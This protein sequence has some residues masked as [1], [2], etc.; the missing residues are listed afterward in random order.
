[1]RSVNEES[2][3]NCVCTAGEKVM[4][5]QP[6]QFDHHVRRVSPHRL[7]FLVFISTQ[8]LQT[9]NVH[10]KRCSQALRILNIQGKPLGRGRIRHFSPTLTLRIGCLHAEE[11]TFMVLEGSTAD[12]ILGRPWM[13]QHQPRINWDT[14]EILQWRDACFQSCLSSVQKPSKSRSLSSTTP[15][16]PT[17]SIN[18]TSVESPEVDHKVEIPPEYQAFQ[19]V[20]SKRLASQLPPHRPWDCAIDLLPDGGLRPCINYRHLN[21][22]TVK[23]NYPLPLVPAALEQLWG[24]CIFSTLELRSAYNLIRIRRGDEWKTAFVTPS[25]HYEYQ[26]MPYGLSNSPA[27]FQ[28]YM[29]EVF[30]NFYLRFIHNCA[31]LS[32]PL[33]S[34]LKGWP[35]SLSL[36]P[37]ASE[38][39]QQL[40]Q[41]FQTAPILVHPNPDLQFIVEMDASSTGVGA[42][43]SQR[44]GDPPRLHPCA[45]YSKKFSPAEQNYDIGNRELLAIKLALEEWRHWLEGAHHKFEVITALVILNTCEKLKD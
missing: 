12:S 21:S 45:F 19:D 14:G 36:T 32:S 39:F 4:S 13:S 23:Y 10:K 44:Q 33:T 35:K 38:A 17:L 30:A 24:A 11:I 2:L 16:Q 8:L 6:V 22:Q 1:M 3:I 7:G 34:A 29:N 26:V 9:L 41:A 15:E 25:G 20:F 28:G 42:V 37:A 40:K 18:S 43:L 31:L 27:G 5:S